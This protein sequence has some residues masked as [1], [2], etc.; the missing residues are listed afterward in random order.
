MRKP[1]SYIK[2]KGGKIKP[3]PKCP[4]MTARGAAGKKDKEAEH[5]AEK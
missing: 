2:D 5:A 1:G 4:A 3:N